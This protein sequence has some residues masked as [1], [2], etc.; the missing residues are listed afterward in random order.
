MERRKVFVEVTLK[1][2]ADGHKRPLT[3]L[4]EDGCVY[5][6]DRLVDIRRAAST[7][8]G[9]C[10]VRYTVIICGKETY[11]FEEDNRWFV[12]AKVSGVKV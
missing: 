10:G 9:G 4:W 7:K 6:I 5:E 3:I 2:S 12:E 11:L 1:Q 8:V